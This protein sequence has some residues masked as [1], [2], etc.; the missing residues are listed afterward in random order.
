[1][2]RSAAVGTPDETAQAR[3]CVIRAVEVLLKDVLL[4]AGPRAQGAA[5]QADRPPC[6]IGHRQG[7]LYAHG[8]DDTR[9]RPGLIPAHWAGAILVL[10]LIGVSGSVPVPLQRPVRVPSEDLLP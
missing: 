4:R 9:Q 10:V 5:R 1:M 6:P 8:L 3:R 7:G 2:K